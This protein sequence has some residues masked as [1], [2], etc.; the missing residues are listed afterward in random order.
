[1]KIE[2]V[3][4]RIRNPEWREYL[5][6]VTKGAKTTG[7]VIARYDGAIAYVDEKIGV[8]MDFWRNVAFWM[9]VLLY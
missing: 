5:R 2:D 7:K 6:K 3:L 8:L 9:S 1:M 4:R